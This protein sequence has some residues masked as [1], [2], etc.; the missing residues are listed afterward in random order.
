MQILIYTELFIGTVHFNTVD[1]DKND[2][3]ETLTNN[4]HNVEFKLD[5]GSHANIIPKHVFDKV[6]IKLSTAHK[7]KGKISHVWWKQNLTE[8]HNSGMSC[9][10]PKI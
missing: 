5:T 10:W 2:W 6:G 7:H 3:I 8:L 4:D 9:V 1:Q